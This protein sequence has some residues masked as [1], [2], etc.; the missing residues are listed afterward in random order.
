MTAILVSH[1]Q[2]KLLIYCP[3]KG[4][5]TEVSQI[6]DYYPLCMQGK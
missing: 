1:G 5:N 4:N 6:M 2:A 3:F